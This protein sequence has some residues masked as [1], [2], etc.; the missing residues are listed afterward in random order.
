VQDPCGH[1]HHQE[2]AGAQ[3]RGGGRHGE[4]EEVLP[5]HVRSG[6]THRQLRA[7]F[8]HEKPLP[9]DKGKPAAGDGDAPGDTGEE[10]LGEEVPLADPCQ[11]FDVLIQRLQHVI[12]SKI[13][14]HFAS[15]NIFDADPELKSMPDL[16]GM[17]MRDLQRLVDA[18]GLYRVGNTEG[19]ANLYFECNEA[20]DTLLNRTEVLGRIIRVIEEFSK[21]LAADLLQRGELG[22]D[23]EAGMYAVKIL[24][25][26]GGPEVTATPGAFSITP[27]GGIR[28]HR[29]RLDYMIR[30]VACLGIDDSA[31][32]D[33][34]T[35]FPPFKA[36][37]L[38]VP[39]EL[40]H[41][42]DAQRC[43]VHEMGHG[44]ALV[45]SYMGSQDGYAWGQHWA[46]A[47]DIDGRSSANCIRIIA[48]FGRKAR[49]SPSLGELFP[50]TSGFPAPSPSDPQFL[51]PANWL[52][53]PALATTETHFHRQ[54]SESS[55]RSD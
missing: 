30:T 54:I 7:F 21:R 2:A 52:E 24:L 4:E 12:D 41:L 46:S 55:R 5:G 34:S 53:D 25:Y 49:G 3:G 44:T 36:E 40:R 42:P 8:H 11:D 27:R 19:E 1:H 17:I 22:E 6:S 28:K 14:P 43:F 10:H 23:E 38:C 51:I 13:E 47:L 18:N 37:P 26:P 16:P 15:F 20:I 45:T 35:R 32:V 9:E 39:P 31:G 33:G 48:D 29:D 50:T